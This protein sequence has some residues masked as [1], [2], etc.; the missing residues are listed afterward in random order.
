MYSTAVEIIFIVSFAISFCIGIYFAH[1]C[2]KD[3]EK[4]KV[5][6]YPDEITE[7]DLPA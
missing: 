2:L 4:Y 7:D 3:I 5:K 6:I 1:K